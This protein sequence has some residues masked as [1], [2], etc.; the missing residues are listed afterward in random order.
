MIKGI[1]HVGISVSSLERSIA[2]Y[3]EMLGLEL[4]GPIVPFEGPLFEQVMALKSPKGRIGFM[5]N[6]QVQL[7]LFEFERPRPAAQNPDYAVADHG[8]SHFGIDVIDIDTLYQ[9]LSAAGVRFHCP[10]LTF[11]SGVKATYARDIDGNVFELLERP[12]A[13][14]EAR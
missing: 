7:E 1:N 10:V 11:P 9:R 3:R 12:A 6:G 8:I 4:A 2:F 13:T 14:R 5:S